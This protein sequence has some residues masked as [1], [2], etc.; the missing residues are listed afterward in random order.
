M[1]GAGSA[2]DAA[3]GGVAAAVAKNIAQASATLA[4]EPVEGVQKAETAVTELQGQD[5]QSA[6]DL[7]SASQGMQ[8]MPPAGGASSA[9]T[10]AVS[11]AMSAS[12]PND[13]F[14]GDSWQDDW[15]PVDPGG[16]A[17]GPGAIGPVPAELVSN[18]TDPDWHWEYDDFGFPIRVVDG[19]DLD[20]GGAAGGGFGG[21]APVSNTGTVMPPTPDRSV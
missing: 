1:P 5:A 19:D 9:P 4:P 6:A 2:I 12:D 21:T 18:T 16:A 15:H 17:A 3:A 20:M 7:K 13:W 11:T 10:R 14:E 8:A